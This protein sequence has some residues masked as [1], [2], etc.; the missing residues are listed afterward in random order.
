MA[1]KLINKSRTRSGVYSVSHYKDITIAFKI[2]L[3]QAYQFVKFFL[4]LTANKIN[5][6]LETVVY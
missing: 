6:N 3:N 5:E 2:I 4:S 1:I